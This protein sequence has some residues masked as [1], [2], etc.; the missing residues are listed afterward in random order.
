MSTLDVTVPCV[1]GPDYRTCAV[2]QRALAEREAQTARRKRRPGALTR[3]TSGPPPA[4]PSPVPVDPEAL[5]AARQAARE[6]ARQATERAH[7]ARARARAV[8]NDEA[9]AR[10]RSIL[11]ELKTYRQA[12]EPRP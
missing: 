1:H 3:S 8:A 5:E 9:A 12:Q 2:C 7:T 11:A 4:R 6:A 10:N